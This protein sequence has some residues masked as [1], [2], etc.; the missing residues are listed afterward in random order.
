M[1]CSIGLLLFLVAHGASAGEAARAYLEDFRLGDA[2]IRVEGWRELDPGRAEAACRALGYDC[3][4]DPDPA[5]AATRYLKPQFATG[6]YRGT[7]RVLRQRGGSY[8]GSFEAPPGFRICKAGIDLVGGEI[9]RG[10]LF[11]GSIQRTGRDGLGFYAA[12]PADGS[13]VI[14][15]RLLTIA[16][17]AARFAPDICWPDGT[18]VF[19]CVGDR[20]CQASHVYPEAELR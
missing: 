11:A 18:I 13:G 7:A 4:D 12:L 3:G 14:A 8:Y 19:L 15:F 2:T 20:R 10:A 9:S 16:V 1:R 6:L 17:P 5:R